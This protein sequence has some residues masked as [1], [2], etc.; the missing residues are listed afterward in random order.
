[1]AFFFKL[2]S[3]DL[4]YNVSS[5]TNFVLGPFPVKTKPLQVMQYL[6]VSMKRGHTNTASKYLNYT[7]YASYL[8]TPLTF[9]HYKIY[10]KI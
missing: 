4:V 8:R 7:Q 3:F 1:M 2:V 10:N 9:L 5:L 6:T